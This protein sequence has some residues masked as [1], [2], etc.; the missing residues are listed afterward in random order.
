MK[1]D[2]AAIKEKHVIGLGLFVALLNIVFIVTENFWGLVIPFAITFI[3]FIVF[4]LDKALLF[5]VFATPLSVLYYNPQFRVGFTLPTEPLIFGIMILFFAKVLYHG[6]FD[7][8]IIKHP[9]SL[10]LLFNLLWMFV[11]AIT[12]EIP[13]VSFKYFLA[14]LWFISVFFYLISQMFKQEHKIRRFIWLYALPLSGVVIY[15]I[16]IHSQYDCTRDAAGWVMSPF[17]ADHTVYGAILAMFIPVLFA[18]AFLLNYDINMRFLATVVFLILMVGVVLSFTRAAWVSLVGAFV[19]MLMIVFKMR[20]WVFFLLVAAF[21]GALHYF[22]GDLEERFQNTKAVSSDN[23]TEHVQ[24][25]SNI[26]TDASN[27]ERINRWKSAFRM[28]EEKPF[29][30]FGPGTYMFKYAPYQKPH[31]MTIISTNAGDKGNAHSEY[32]GPLA[33]SGVLGLVSVLLIVY[34]TIITGIRVYNRLEDR[35]L[36]ILAITLLMGLITYWIHGFLNNFLDM[37]K[38][39]CPVFGFSAVL[40]VLDCYYAKDGKAEG[41]QSKSTSA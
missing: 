37:D 16:I 13:F 8:R 22:W 34:F 24:S 31:E 21:F 11:T 4:A 41:D 19:V 5:L 29:L 25:I 23:L 36:K 17:F 38:A 33:E 18:F 7:P 2:L 14:R 28:F 3:A 39:A 9:L 40:V 32:I 15:T 35:N 6:R 10:A 27:L 26:S 30:G 12:S 20:R 1:L